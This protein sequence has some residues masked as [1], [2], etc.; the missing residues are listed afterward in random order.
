MN[1]V[2]WNTVLLDGRVRPEQL[3]EWIDHS[4]G[5]VSRLMNKGK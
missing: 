3:K 5:L 1:K 4:Y 2:H